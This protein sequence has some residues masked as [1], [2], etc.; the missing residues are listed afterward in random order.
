M[1]AGNTR[2]NNEVDDLKKRLASIET[3]LAQLVEAF[4]SKDNSENNEDDND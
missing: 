4:N 2:L 3:T 1:K